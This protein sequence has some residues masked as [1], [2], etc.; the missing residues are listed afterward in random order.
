M[1]TK[2][3]I[4]NRR[5]SSDANF[6]TL[7]LGVLVVTGSFLPLSASAE[8][9]P[10]ADIASAATSFIISARQLDPERHSV[11]AQAPD[12]RLRLIKCNK[13]LEAEVLSARRQS[14]RVTVKVSCNGT[15][16]WKVYVPVQIASY[17]DV[18]VAR[19]SLPRGHIL[20]AAD[21]SL[22][23]DNV[24]HHSAGYL[25]TLQSAIGSVL[26]QS[27]TAGAVLTPGQ[28]K[29]NNAVERGQAVTLVA[30]QHGIS[31]RMAGVA[32]DSG[33]LGARITAKNAN[34]GTIVEGTVL[35]N[36]EIRVTGRMR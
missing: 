24:T 13:P 7:W 29:Q 10:P 27:V 22:R 21:I 6:L 14:S 26:R 32:M 5:K 23:R 25:I 28:L 36:A 12:A 4:S 31:I 17:S 34:S 18:V 19:R 15:N 9:Q 1:T 3:S 2:H 20:S 35:A 8:W 33:P 16:P 11:K 30:E